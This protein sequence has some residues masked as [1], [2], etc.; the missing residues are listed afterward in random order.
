M[1]THGLHIAESNLDLV[2]E[3]SF[4]NSHVHWQHCSCG[5][6]WLLAMSLRVVWRAL[7]SFWSVTAVRLLAVGRLS[8]IGGL[9]RCI[10]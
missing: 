6:T 5:A 1:E 2:P 4:S 3:T 9:S 10:V 8:S 7:I